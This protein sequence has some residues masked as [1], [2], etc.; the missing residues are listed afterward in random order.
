MQDNVVDFLEQL[1]S[2]C[3]GMMD[4]GEKLMGNVGETSG[5]GRGESS[6]GDF[7]RELR[8]P[9]EESRRG[10]RG[11]SIF[12]LALGLEKGTAEIDHEEY[13]KELTDVLDEMKK[14]TE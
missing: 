7:R 2:V 5:Q 1:S 13:L 6:R 14:T 11:L 3:D 12:D 4:E 8:K 10:G 9:R